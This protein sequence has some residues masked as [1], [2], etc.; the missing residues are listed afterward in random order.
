[1]GCGHR[2]TAHP[3]PGERQGSDAVLHVVFDTHSDMSSNTIGAI[4][5]TSNH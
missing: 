1:M 5:K 2:K 4:I 3:P